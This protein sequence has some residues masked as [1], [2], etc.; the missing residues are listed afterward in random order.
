MFDVHKGKQN[1]V[2]LGPQRNKNRH[3]NSVSAIAAKPGCKQ[4]PS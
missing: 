4:S 2:L 3:T 1:V